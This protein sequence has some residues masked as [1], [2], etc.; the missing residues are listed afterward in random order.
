MRVV[1][2]ALLLTAG[3]IAI[4]FCGAIVSFLRTIGDIGSDDPQAQIKGL[5]AFG[6][7][8]ICVLAALRIALQAG[9]DQ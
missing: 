2:L 9:R 7:C 1:A 4:R 3:I 8:A 5:A 6:F